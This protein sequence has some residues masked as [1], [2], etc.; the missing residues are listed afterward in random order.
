MTSSFDPEGH[1]AATLAAIPELQGAR[2][3]EIGAGDGRMTWNYA[4]RA[5]FVVGVD[6]DGESLGYMLEDRPATLRR[7]VSG[8]VAESE[9]LPFAGERFDAAVLAWSL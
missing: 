9:Y 8:V 7:R 4:R 6:P 1:E 3:L 5:R 2:V